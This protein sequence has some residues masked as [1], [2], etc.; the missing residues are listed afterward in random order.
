[1]YYSLYNETIVSSIPLEEFGVQKSEH[2]SLSSAITIEYAVSP[3]KIYTKYTNHQTSLNEDYGYY[4]IEDIA[5]FEIFSGKKIVVNHFNEID[6]DVIHTLLNF[7]FAILFNQRQKYV[8]HA[9]SVFY[10]DKVFCFCGSTQSGKSSIASYLIKSGGS[11][12]S[13]DT[14]VFD[15]INDELV[16]LPS[17]NFIKLSDEVGQYTDII[18]SEPITFLK[19]LTDRKGYV[20]A[21][22][23]FET[24]TRPVDYFIYLEWSEDDS[25]LKLLDNESSLKKILQNEFISYSKE[26]SHIRFKAATRL[27]NQAN[28]YLYSREKKLNTL[29]DFLAIVKKNML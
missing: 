22:E 18:S 15:L 10:E 13:E 26:S 8:L 20:L 29:D 1:M 21:S 6:N 17:Y 23:R 4:F 2:P 19:K 14:C 27:I 3:S 16:I 5:M 28:H 12:I 25:I 11:L 9:S 7:P 24:R